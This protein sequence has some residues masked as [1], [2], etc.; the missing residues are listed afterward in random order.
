MALNQREF[1]T[2]KNTVLR[3]GLLAEGPRVVRQKMLPYQWEAQHD[4]L[5]GVEPSSAVRNLRIAA[6]EERGEYHGMVFQDSYVAKWLEAMAFRRS[7]Q[8]VPEW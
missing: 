3:S 2:C 6:G 7:T 8:P 5:P 1:T 4:R